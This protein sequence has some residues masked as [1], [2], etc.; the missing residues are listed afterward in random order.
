MKPHPG[1]EKH[2]VDNL[3]LDIEAIRLDYYTLEDAMK[4]VSREMTTI[5]QSIFKL[6]KRANELIECCEIDQDF[7][8]IFKD[9]PKAIE[10]SEYAKRKM[11][12]KIRE[13][14]HMR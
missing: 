14:R 1:Y 6:C 10:I 9:I 2:H 12:K 3:K 7:V 4:K 8:E 11:R 13:R 5:K